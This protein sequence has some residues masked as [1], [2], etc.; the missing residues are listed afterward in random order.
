MIVGYINVFL[1]SVNIISII[2]KLCYSNT[3]TPFCIMPFC[4]TNFIINFLK[5]YYGGEIQASCINYRFTKILSCACIAELSVM[6][7]DTYAGSNIPA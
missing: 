1:R 2:S 4:E 5:E 7:L 6:L 3:D